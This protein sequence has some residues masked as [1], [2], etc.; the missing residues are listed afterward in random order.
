MASPGSGNA[1]KA[2]APAVP[3][4][5]EEAAKADPGEMNKIKQAQQ[6]SSSGRFGGEKAKPAKKSEAEEEQSW[7]ECELVGEDDE[8]IPGEKYRITLPDGTVNEGTLDDKG[9]VRVEDIQS[10]TCQIT[11][12]DLDKD[13]WEKI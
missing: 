11:F 8:P 5:P 9:F 6:A 1:G 2:V 3:K 13:A 7:I 10:G 4:K 12:P